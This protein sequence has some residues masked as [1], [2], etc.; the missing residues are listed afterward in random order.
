MKRENGV[1]LNSGPMR[2]RDNMKTLLSLAAL[3]GILFTTAA[4]AETVLPA[5]DQGTVRVTVMD[6]DG[7]VIPDAPV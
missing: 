5:A 2:G 7:K 6:A 4:H 3:T 1:P